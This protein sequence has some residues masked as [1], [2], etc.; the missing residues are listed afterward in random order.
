MGVGLVRGTFGIRG[1]RNLAPD[2][3]RMLC[4]GLKRETGAL[5]LWRIAPTVIA[6]TSR[7]NTC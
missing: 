7:V 6:S 3:D 4:F 5:S 2:C 1:G